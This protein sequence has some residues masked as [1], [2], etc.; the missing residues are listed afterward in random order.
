MQSDCQRRFPTHSLYLHYA[1]TTQQIPL[2]KV[3]PLCEL[4]LQSFTFL[5]LHTL[6]E[7]V[8]ISA[9]FCPKHM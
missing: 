8:S 7:L 5:Y 3:G 1:Y 4:S 2:N 9:Y 6:S